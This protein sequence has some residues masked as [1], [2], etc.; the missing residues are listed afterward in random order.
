MSG[1][2]TALKV[3]IDG[4]AGAGKSTV[5]KIA[6][7]KLGYLYLDTGAMYRAATVLALRKGLSMEEPDEIA[8][9]V[10]Q[11]KI[12]LVPAA[13]ADGSPILKVFLDDEDITFEI[14]SR[15][16]S[17][18]VSPLSTIGPVR[19]SLVA[20]QRRL[21]QSGGVVLDGRD[22]GTVVLP[23]AEVK[24]FLTASAAERAKRRMKEFE[25]RGEN[26]EFDTVLK[27]IIERD[28]RD[29]TREI[30][31]LKK[32]PDA[33]EVITDGM[34]INEVVEKILDLCSQAKL[35]ERSRR[36]LI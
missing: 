33:S 32:A 30:A 10:A 3:A 36:E 24:I 31:P 34:T 16:V 14:R 18:M 21:A 35:H 2:T 22:I 29:S 4:P 9:A 19:D 26:V 13:N 17:L 27:E 25:A 7:K 15:E 12:D 1:H 6:A 28:R 5:A 23:N 11:A 8:E 20:Q